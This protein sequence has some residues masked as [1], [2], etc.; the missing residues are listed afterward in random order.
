MPVSGVNALNSEELS[1]QGDESLT[2]MRSVAVL[3]WRTVD[4]P[5][6]EPA[7]GSGVRTEAE[8]GALRVQ[9]FEA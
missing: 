3:N 6:I 5:V 1:V 8:V 2:L 9:A 4:G 7:G